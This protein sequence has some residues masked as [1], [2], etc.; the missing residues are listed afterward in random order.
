[1]YSHVVDFVYGSLRNRNDITVSKSYRNK[2][3]SRDLKQ[4]LADAKVHVSARQQ[5][6]TPSLGTPSNI[7]VIIYASL[8]SNLMG[9]NFLA[10]R[11]VL[12]SFVWPLLPHK[13]AKSSEIPRK[14]ELIAVHGQP[15]SSI[16]VSIER[17]YTLVINSNVGRISYRFRNNHA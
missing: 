13:F 8:K 17:A 3:T 7:N 2:I 5:C 9:Y 16:L 15:R 4:S 10:D 14:F 11:K 12:S 6:V 1:L